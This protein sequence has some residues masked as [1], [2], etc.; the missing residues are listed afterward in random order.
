MAD[1]QLWATWPSSFAAGSTSSTRSVS[2]FKR[3][4]ALAPGQP[5]Q[6]VR[7]HMRMPTISRDAIQNKI[8]IHNYMYALSDSHSYFMYNSKLQV[9]DKNCTRSITTRYDFT[10]NNTTLQALC[11][12]R[13]QSNHKRAGHSQHIQKKLQEFWV[14]EEGI[15]FVQALSNRTPC[16][17]LYPVAEIMVPAGIN[18]TL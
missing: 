14:T 3:S 9:R 17:E 18:S 8:C 5:R 12:Y 4:S 2:A 7:S 6:P 15:R 10:N 16:N 11:E 13:L 1:A